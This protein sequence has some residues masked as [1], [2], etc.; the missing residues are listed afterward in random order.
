[1]GS[2][3]TTKVD[4]SDNSVGGENHPAHKADT[5]KNTCLDVII[6]SVFVIFCVIWLIVGVYAF[7]EGNPAHL[8][9]PHNSAGEL[10][11]SKKQSASDE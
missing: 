3:L 7:S 9:H 11:G 5:R 10:C 8:L 4:A 2:S 6:L 1:M